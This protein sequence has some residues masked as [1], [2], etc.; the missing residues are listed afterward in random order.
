MWF[1]ILLGIAGLIVVRG[2]KNEVNH[3][4]PSFKDVRGSRMS[5]GLVLPLDAR[6]RIKR[7]L[8]LA[9]VSDSSILDK[10]ITPPVSLKCPDIYYRLKDFN[11]GKDPRAPHPATVWYEKDVNGVNHERRTC[12]CIGGAAWIG[13]WDRYQPNRFSHLYGGWINTD[14][15]LMDARGSK[16][17][18]VE[19][20]AP[21]PGCYVVCA[22]GSPGHK[23]GHIGTVIDVPIN[24]DASS[25]QSWESL[26]VVDVASR[27]SNKVN[28]VTTG[29][30]W[31]GTNAGFVVSVMK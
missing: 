30:G 5:R 7:A 16:K 8:Y 27:G 17:C 3:Q 20:P 21:V 4:A 25:R 14:S 31:Y 1:P 6:Q 26:K 24:W 12:D 13:G 9:Q 15:M 18:F 10:W 2:R 23:V 22:S 11:G 28:G 29:R 19:L